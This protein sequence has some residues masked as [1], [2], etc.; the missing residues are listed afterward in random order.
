MMIP[1][2]VITTKICGWRMFT[3]RI[4]IASTP[5]MIDGM[6][7]VRVFGCTRARCVPAGR[8]LS[9]AIANIIR[10]VAVWTAR[11]QTVMAITT[12]HRKM[13]PIVPPRTSRMM[14]WRP[15]PACRSPGR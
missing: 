2:E 10:I 4:A 5:T 7:G 11:Q 9:R 12:H 6:I 1:I 15:P 13:S 8:L 3:T 14:N